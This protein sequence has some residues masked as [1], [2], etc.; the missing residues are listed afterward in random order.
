MLQPLRY[1]SL[2]SLKWASR[3]ARSAQIGLGK[4]KTPAIA[5]RQ[6][7]LPSHLG[8]GIVFSILDPTTLAS[9]MASMLVLFVPYVEYTIGRYV[10]VILLGV[11]CN[12]SFPFLAFPAA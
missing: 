12:I 6:G 8:Y 10:H 7:P 9:F 2:G 4:E 3:R 1:L 11:L 5:Y